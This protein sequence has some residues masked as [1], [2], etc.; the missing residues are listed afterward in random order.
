MQLE[1]A[2]GV[3]A[4]AAAVP[5]FF[6]ASV[7]VNTWPVLTVPELGVSVAEIAAAACTVMAAAVTVPVVTVAALF[8][9][10]PLAEVLSARVPA[11]VVE[12]PV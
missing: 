12:Q 11:V 3:T 1:M 8:A 10:V 2:T 6:T 7:A 5:L 9:S 4:F